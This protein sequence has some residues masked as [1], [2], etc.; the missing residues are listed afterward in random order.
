MHP[1]GI[2][3]KEILWSLIWLVLL[4]L[5]LS[6]VK[7]Q[8]YKCAY[9][10][11][12]LCFC[13]VNFKYS[14]SEITGAIWLKFTL[15][16]HKM[17]LM[18]VSKLRLMGGTE[19]TLSITRPRGVTKTQPNSHKMFLKAPQSAQATNVTLVSSEYHWISFYYCYQAKKG[20]CLVVDWPWW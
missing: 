14:K 3:L 8:K 5:V 13:L 7:T 15:C 18:H 4:L 11:F 17:S 10:I 16:Y 2:I 19:V 12:C 6:Q 20:F 1:H 9:F